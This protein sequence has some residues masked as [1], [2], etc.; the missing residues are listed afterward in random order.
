VTVTDGV[1]TVDT[2]PKCEDLVLAARNSVEKDS[3]KHLA[4]HIGF[5]FNYL[6]SDSRRGE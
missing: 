6:T 1:V 5:G 2:E 3:L 4:V